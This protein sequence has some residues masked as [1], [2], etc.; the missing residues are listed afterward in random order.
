[1]QLCQ[2]EGKVEDINGADSAVESCERVPT[3][4]DSRLLSAP[5]AIAKGEKSNDI[6]SDSSIEISMKV[7]SSALDGQSTKPDSFVSHNVSRSQIGLANVSDT[8]SET[9]AKEIPHRDVKLPTPEAMGNNI[10][11][12]S[13]NLLTSLQSVTADNTGGSFGVIGG[14]PTVGKDNS[15]QSHVPHL[16][17][18]ISTLTDA[19]QQPSQF[20]SLFNSNMILGSAN[21]PNSTSPRS[22]SILSDTRLKAITSKTNINV[23]P[24]PIHSHRVAITSGHT[25]EISTNSSS[26]VGLLNERNKVHGAVT[27]QE[28][29]TQLTKIASE[30][31]IM[32]MQAVPVN[33]KS[34]A[35]IAVSTKAQSSLSGN[36]DG[37]KS[38]HE[39]KLASVLP[40]PVPIDL[41]PKLHIPIPAT[42]QD[43]D[44]YGSESVTSGT[45]TI[46]HHNS[47]TTMPSG[48]DEEKYSKVVDSS[49]SL[50][51]A[52]DKN[53]VRS[54]LPTSTDVSP[55][56]GSF[57]MANVP[58]NR[59]Q[60]TAPVKS[61]A[62][63]SKVTTAS[64]KSTNVKK[65]K[66][67]S[68]KDAKVTDRDLLSR[69]SKVQDTSKSTTQPINKPVSQESMNIKAAAAA[70]IKEQQGM[71]QGTS[72]SALMRRYQILDEK[73]RSVERKR[74]MGSKCAPFHASRLKNHWDYVL[75]EMQWMAVDFKQERRWKVKAIRAQ[76]S[77]CAN[78][79][80]VKD[81]DFPPINAGDNIN[82]DDSLYYKWIMS[83]EK[84]VRGESPNATQWKQTAHKISGIFVGGIISMLIGDRERGIIGKGNKKD[85]MSMLTPAAMNKSLRSPAS[86]VLDDLN[87]VDNK[88]NS[89]YRYIVE[90]NAAFSLSKS[91][92]PTKHLTR[93]QKDAAESI[94]GLNSC[95]VG[96]LML[97][98]CL[99]SESGVSGTVN[100]VDIG[101]A[102][103]I[104]AAIVCSWLSSDGNEE[105]PVLVV[106]NKHCVFAWKE[107]IR[108]L[109]E[110]VTFDVLGFENLHNHY[111][112]KSRGDE[113]IAPHVCFC[114]S[115]ETLEILIAVAA[116]AAT[117]SRNLDD[118]LNHGD[119]FI[120]AVSTPAMTQSLRSFPLVLEPY[121]GMRWASVMLDFCRLG[122]AHPTSSRQFSGTCKSM[123][124]SMGTF[125]GEIGTPWNPNG[126]LF[127]LQEDMV[128][129]NASGAF[130]GSSSRV[131][132]NVIFRD[133]QKAKNALH[134]N[135][136]FWLKGVTLLMN[137]CRDRATDVDKLVTKCNRCCIS[138]INFLASHHSRESG[139][140]TYSRR[141]LPSTSMEKKNG[142]TCPTFDSLASSWL[143]FA[144]PSAFATVSSGDSFQSSDVK[145]L[146]ETVNLAALKWIEYK[147]TNSRDSTTG[148]ENESTSSSNNFL[149]KSLLPM[150]QVI[151]ESNT[152]LLVNL[153]STP[154]D[155][156]MHEPDRLTVAFQVKKVDMTQRHR[157]KY[158]HIVDYFCRKTF[159]FEGGVVPF[160]VTTDATAASKPPSLASEKEKERNQEK[161]KR[162]H[163]ENFA[164]ALV[165]LRRLCFH[166]KCIGIV[167]DVDAVPKANVEKDSVGLR[168]CLKSNDANVPGSTCA[169]KM[170]VSFGD[171]HKAGTTGTDEVVSGDEDDLPENKPLILSSGFTLNDLMS[172]NSASKVFGMDCTSNKLN[173]MLE[174]IHEAL[175]VADSKVV[176]VVETI[177]E[178]MMTHMFLDKNHI[179]HLYAGVLGNAGVIAMAAGQSNTGDTDDSR[180]VDITASR[181]C[182]W[183]SAQKVL[184][185]FNDS[186]DP[187]HRIVVIS[188]WLLGDEAISG[189][190][191]QLVSSFT[192]VL[193]HA[194]T[195]VVVVSSDWVTCLTEVDYSTWWSHIDSSKSP[196][197]KITRVVYRNTLEDLLLGSF[198]MESC[199]QRDS[200]ESNLT[201]SSFD[202]GSVIACGMEV[203]DNTHYWKSDV[204]IKCPLSAFQGKAIK[205]VLLNSV[206]TSRM[207][208]DHETGFNID[209]NLPAN[210]A[211]NSAVTSST[212]SKQSPATVFNF[213]KVQDVKKKLP[214]ELAHVEVSFLCAAPLLT[215]RICIQE[216]LSRQQNLLS[217]KEQFVTSCMTPSNSLGEHGTT[218]T[219]LGRGKGKN[220]NLGRGMGK[221][222]LAQGHDGQPV[223]AESLPWNSD[224]KIEDVINRAIA[225]R[226]YIVSLKSAVRRVEKFFFMGD[227]K[228]GCQHVH[229]LPSV[230]SR[231]H[232]HSAPTGHIATIYVYRN[233]ALSPEK[234][235]AHKLCRVFGTNQEVIPTLLPRKVVPDSSKKKLGARSSKKGDRVLDKV[236]CD[237]IYDLLWTID[238]R[239][240]RKASKSSRWHPPGMTWQLV[241]MLVSLRRRESDKQLGKAAARSN[242]IKSPGFNNRGRASSF[243]QG[244][245]TTAFTNH[246]S[247]ISSPK[248][249]SKQLHSQSN[250]H[251]DKNYVYEYVDSFLRDIASG[252]STY[253]DSK[254]DETS[255]VFHS[256]VSEVPAVNFISALM[257]P[258]PSKSCVEDEFT[259]NKLNIFMETLPMVTRN[260]GSD[261]QAFV[262]FQMREQFSRVGLGVSAEEHTLRSLYEPHIQQQRDVARPPV[263]NDG[264]PD[265]INCVLAHG[266]E[267]LD[268][269]RVCLRDCRR[270]GQL[271]DTFLLTNPLDMATGRDSLH[272]PTYLRHFLTIGDGIMSGMCGDNFD[273]LSLVFKGCDERRFSSIR[274]DDVPAAPKRGGGR[275]KAADSSTVK[276]S[277][278]GT[279]EDS[280]KQGATKSGPKEKAITI[281]SGIVQSQNGLPSKEPTITSVK[282]RHVSDMPRYHVDGTG[283]RKRQYSTVDMANS[284]PAAKRKKSLTNS[285]NLTLGSSSTG[286]NA[287][288]ALS[289]AGT[290]DKK[291]ASVLLQDP[292]RA[293][294]FHSSVIMAGMKLLDN[295]TGNTK[296]KPWTELETKVLLDISGTL[297]DSVLPTE[298]SEDERP[299]PSVP[300]CE[301]LENIA[302][303][304]VSANQKS[305]PVATTW[306][307]DKVL[308]SVA[309]LA[310]L[311]SVSS[312]NQSMHS[313]QD[314]VYQYK[315]QARQ[316]T[317]RKQRLQCQ[318]EKK[319]G[320]EPKPNISYGVSNV[321]NAAYFADGKDTPSTTTTPP[322]SQNLNSV[323]ND[324]ASSPPLAHSNNAAAATALIRNNNVTDSQ[325]RKRVRSVFGLSKVSDLFHP[326]D[327][328]ESKGK[329]FVNSSM[330]LQQNDTISLANSS[331][332][333]RP[334]L[335]STCGTSNVPMI[336]GSTTARLSPNTALLAAPSHSSH[337]KEVMKAKTLNPLKIADNMKLLHD[338]HKSQ[339]ID[340]T[341]DVNANTTFAANELDKEKVHWE[342][343]RAEKGRSMTSNT[344]MPG[345]QSSTHLSGSRNIN[346][347]SPDSSS[348]E[349]AS[350]TVGAPMSRVAKQNVDNVFSS[351]IDDA[352]AIKKTNSNTPLHVK[353]VHTGEN[354]VSMS[355]TGNRDSPVIKDMGRGKIPATV[356]V[357]P[358]GKIASSSATSGPDL[359]A[360]CTQ[361]DQQHVKLASLSSLSPMANYSSLP[362][363]QPV[364][365]GMS[366][367]PPIISL[368]QNISRNAQPQGKPPSPAI[369][370]NLS[371]SVDSTD[372]AIG[373]AGTT[374]YTCSNITISN[375]DGK[376][377]EIEK[378]LNSEQ[379][380]GGGNGVQIST[381][382]C[383]EHTVSSSTGRQRAATGSGFSNKSNDLL[384]LKKRAERDP[385]LKA[386]V[387]AILSNSSISDHKKSEMLK[388]LMEKTCDVSGS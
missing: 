346:K 64:F 143:S 316:H 369:N 156:I 135:Y 349:L 40:L 35:E 132:D 155:G 372:S 96:G 237:G 104:G 167:S 285:T 71:T 235:N 15:S 157:K 81:R 221:G 358:R 384:Q 364:T 259:Y 350:T 176:V 332:D 38:S 151:V 82:Y 33:T 302:L 192:S 191:H 374:K 323:S 136:E 388:I 11:S 119:S 172:P 219:S 61:V 379:I 321:P 112:L 210:S 18:G 241:R 161:V 276:E 387:V 283:W 244:A 273:E 173:G 87:S 307:L 345:A 80:Y 27:Q 125:P 5:S 215:S 127:T 262:Q 274:K 22:N 58:E 218:P 201:D 311:S 313:A 57:K 25:N 327:K 183:Y 116:S 74:M 70:L 257:T 189:E 110:N 286:L 93:Y 76:A 44:R 198:N 88:V 8:C 278:C 216:E 195:D 84:N 102:I 105:G 98:N 185:K 169:S 51:T 63:V 21:V 12:N 154:E 255:D 122:V 277:H 187:H 77:L 107:E 291:S 103:T 32:D 256:P 268:A 331:I 73:L 326:F 124:H 39:G 264:V 300:V 153:D 315:F 243:I 208:S 50:S 13:T 232:S 86:L 312:K 111:G 377:S 199:Y 361:Q 269:F 108:K 79:V 353:Q 149:R 165:A 368:T 78:S 280:V 28:S 319:Y 204:R 310:S 217:Q 178:Q 118:D 29:D 337:A 367:P 299:V 31:R 322:L 225:A 329:Y 141:G 336:S 249:K 240:P 123:S 129:D 36:C 211:M 236:Y 224:R 339:Q 265:N 295:T 162:Q 46:P 354:P 106:T 41:P 308:S 370:T 284:S 59:N 177:E 347:R 245:E 139:Y 288:S 303:A 239:N 230:L 133:L 95:G 222:L 45:V 150:M 275:K 146:S 2:A 344:A 197:K 362:N 382:N 131:V 281:S 294:P 292:Y 298:N 223:H 341:K 270:K 180:S 65:V 254:P 109:R 140:A 4:K 363:N 317:Y 17:S 42:Q 37:H 242:T 10:L 166:E 94:V 287:S 338:E 16:L 365:A 247:P 220:I 386:Q 47:M 142:L 100:I 24:I 301:T 306:I 212:T 158:E 164:L 62:P 145:Y 333:S 89:T 152:P 163:E 381:A 83:M 138:N 272:C 213:L 233:E 200:K 325:A 97:T 205:D 9:E 19:Q 179:S 282:A 144:I 137:L 371:T 203:G 188:R 117:A 226:Q 376:S 101:S 352:S 250:R 114:T 52:I 380:N 357:V 228:N 26:S 147:D 309:P 271:V 23:E 351:H 99:E 193:P 190:A 328:D 324:S 60:R 227:G 6:N 206:H 383:T 182:N 248:E 91:S 14:V 260:A 194:A 1:M 34:A 335:P 320:E 207:H 251:C 121:R 120:G 290:V 181:I 246:L 385:L 30:K 113:F 43:S 128:G 289:K 7:E 160:P 67:P 170:S 334:T 48:G 68:D 54:A 3:T 261:F 266:S 293:Q 340:T 252:A 202:T 296:K 342:R 55:P 314:V 373:K 159:V 297:Q 56:G 304:N 148:Y 238:E 366:L 184:M 343:E 279:N 378:N 214:V 318:L 49:S 267:Q 348:S 69:D 234:V 72:M 174:I 53:G 134:A 92:C 229:F 330:S 126:M 355:D 85:S 115:Y 130:S 75:D 186:K 66:Q 171:F 305:L 253:D 375:S 231:K 90:E 263:T 196:R 209:T 175:S 168:S 258:S 359:S 360:P 20:S 356:D